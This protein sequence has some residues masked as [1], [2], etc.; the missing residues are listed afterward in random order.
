MLI[1]KKKDQASSFAPYKKSSIVC[2]KLVLKAGNS[3]LKKAGS[4]NS[5]FSYQLPNTKK[6]NT[7]NTT[8]K[9]LIDLPLLYLHFGIIV[10]SKEFK[11][12]AGMFSEP[13]P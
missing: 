9:Q 4:S 8:I 3:F 2:K 13:T 6:L 12:I 7:L 11:G 10:N 5:A 1:T